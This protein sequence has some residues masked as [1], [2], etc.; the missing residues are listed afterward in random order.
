[1]PSVERWLP[2]PGWEGRYSVSDEGRVRSETRT[3]VYPDG[4]ARVFKGRVLKCGLDTSGYHHASLSDQGRHTVLSVHLLVLAA[5]VGPRPAGSEEVRHLDGDKTNNR[6]ENLRYGTRSEN[7]LD[8]VRLGVHHL[9]KLTACHEGHEFS[10]ENT[11]RTPDG[12]RQ[13]KTCR[14][15]RDMARRA[16]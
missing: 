7:Q 6:L 8:N 14:R 9:S 4:S 5:F 16:A 2:I 13:C 3:T 10:P 15:S 12:R 11:Y 1:M